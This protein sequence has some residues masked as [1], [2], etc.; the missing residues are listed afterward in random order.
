MFE[1]LLAKLAAGLD[2]GQ[3]PYM[4]IGG[5]AV[6]V[7]GRPRL[8]Q[9]IDLTLGADNSHLEEIMKICKE[10]SL[11]PLPEDVDDFV[12]S[13]NVLPTVEPGIK[14][15]VDFIFSFT[16]YEKQAIDRNTTV[17]LDGYPVKF[18]SPEDLI[19]HKLFAGRTRDLEDI[20]GVV[21]RQKEKLDITYLTKWAEEFSKVPG[22]ESILSKLKELLSV[23]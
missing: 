4:V 11:Q 9:D 17:T 3:I 19:L 23:K 14:I 6:L 15:R 10:I 18:A 12:K 22:K 8:T 21:L 20:E 7:H 1:K 16:P 13:T 2:K 5:Q